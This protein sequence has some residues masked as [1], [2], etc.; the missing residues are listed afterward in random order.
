MFDLQS[1]Y[2]TDE[3]QNFDLLDSLM[4]KIPGPENYQGSVGDY[5]YQAQ[6][7][8]S[9]CDRLLIVRYATSPSR[10][11]CWAVTRGT[12]A[13]LAIAPLSTV[14]TTVATTVS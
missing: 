14:P 4:E 3:I 8:V 1:S 11:L 12:L 2:A 13:T 9:L 5:D 10:T 7:R 6:A